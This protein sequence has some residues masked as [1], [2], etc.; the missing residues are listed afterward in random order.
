MISCCEAGEVAYPGPCPW[1]EKVAWE[2]SRSTV[3][4]PPAPDPAE[5]LAVL[6][7]L[8]AWW[9]NQDKYVDPCERLSDLNDVIVD[10]ARALVEREDT[11]HG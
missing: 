7:E 4:T 8:V 3:D 11:S 6:G 1:H 9:D 10:R 5:A 2:A